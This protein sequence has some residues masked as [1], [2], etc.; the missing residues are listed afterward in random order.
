M[1]SFVNP[2]VSISPATE[3]TPRIVTYDFHDGERTPKDLQLSYFNFGGKAEAIRLLAFHGR[4]S[5]SD[6]RF[7]RHQFAALKSSGQLLFGQM[8]TLT[9]KGTQQV[10]QCNAILRLVARLSTSEPSLYP[11]DEPV[12]CGII[13]AILDLDSDIFTPIV[14][15]NYKERFGFD[16]LNDSTSSPLID[17][18]TK[19]LKDRV[20]PQHLSNLSKLIGTSG[21]LGGDWSTPTIADFNFGVRLEYLNNLQEFDRIVEKDV[22]LKEFLDKFKNLP[23]VRAYQNC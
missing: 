1:S 18:V 10:P 5:F 23:S 7:E 2:K 6:H 21:W 4:V 8:P 11:V 14:V 13:D 20:L 16:F 3:S 19:N 22:K 9:V 12:K 15:R 17:D